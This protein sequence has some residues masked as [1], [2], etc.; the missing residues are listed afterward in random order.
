MWT[1][2]PLR[3]ESYHPLSTWIQRTR[4][5]V[6]V[7]NEGNRCF[8]D[9]VMAGLYTPERDRVRPGSYKKFYKI[10]D[11]PTFHPLK[12]PVKLRDILLAAEILV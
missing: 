4:C 5:V 2:D 8:E 12:F 11:A 10:E 3:G 1:L 6:N 7:V 9:A